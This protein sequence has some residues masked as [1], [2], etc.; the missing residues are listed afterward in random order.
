[1]IKKIQKKQVDLKKICKRQIIHITKEVQR[2]KKAA[3]RC[4]KTVTKL[5]EKLS[6]CEG[7]AAKKILIRKIAKAEAK[8]TIYSKKAKKENRKVKSL[9]K[10]EKKIK[11]VGKKTGHHK[12][13]SSKHHKSSTKISKIVKK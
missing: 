5:R 9:K 2:K 12:G 4:E 13:I 7:K 3:K 10:V 8:V 1:M 6:K 11:V